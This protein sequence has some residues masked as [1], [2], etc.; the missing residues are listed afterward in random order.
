MRTVFAVGI[1]VCLATSAGANAGVISSPVDFYPADCNASIG[2]GLTGGATVYVTGQMYILGFPIGDPLSWD[3]SPT[4][5]WGYS[6]KLSNPSGNADLQFDV[7]TLTGGMVEDL[8]VDIKGGADWSVGESYD[9]SET[10]ISNVLA[11]DL[12]LSGN[13]AITSFDWQMA[14]GDPANG[15]IDPNG[16]LSASVGANLAAALKLTILPGT[17]FEYEIDLLDEMYDLNSPLFDLDSRLQGSLGLTDLN[18]SDVGVEIHGD[19]PDFSPASIDE[20]DSYDFTIDV[21]GNTYY[22]ISVGYGIYGGVEVQAPHVDLY[23]TIE[24][25]IPEPMTAG[26]LGLGGMLL[27]LVRR[28][29]LR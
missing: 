29:G 9:W 15:V 13:A 23:G 1:A 20:S 19:L 2:L 5:D 4:A 28:R 11:V 22:K 24:G 6:T 3:Y 8:Y 17:S 18:G 14:A 25:V 21:A 12:S 16:T 10:L 7:P 27:G 26:L